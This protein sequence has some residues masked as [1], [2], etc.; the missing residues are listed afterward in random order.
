MWIVILWINQQVEEFHYKL[1]A[2]E[3]S[4]I[5]P[6]SCAGMIQSTPSAARIWDYGVSLFLMI[7]SHW[8][9][10]TSKCL[11]VWQKLGGMYDCCFKW[12][13]SRTQHSPWYSERQ[14][15][16]LICC[17]RP[18]DNIWSSGKEPPEVVHLELFDWL[19]QWVIIGLKP[20]RILSAKLLVF[21]GGPSMEEEER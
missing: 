2:L 17:I 10:P 11:C 5:H 6:E 20:A 8:D 13:T 12:S 4:P 7:R 21:L 19:S 14:P 3:R 15:D 9:I 18:C 1:G 16:Y